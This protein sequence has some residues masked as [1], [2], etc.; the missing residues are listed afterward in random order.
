MG[1]F[2]SHPTPMYCDNKSAIQIAHNSFFHEQT[3][4]IK[5]DWHLTCR[6]LK[7]GTIILPFVSSLLQFVYFFTKSRSFSVLVFWLANS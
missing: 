4:H 5:I 2:I 3:K 6:H 1:V 7:H